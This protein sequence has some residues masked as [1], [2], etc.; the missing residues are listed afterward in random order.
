[1]KFFFQTHFYG[2]NPHDVG[3]IFSIR[4]LW[5]FIDGVQLYM[6]KTNDKYQV[7]LTY[8]VYITYKLLQPTFKVLVVSTHLAVLVGKNDHSICIVSLHPVQ[9][10]AFH[11]RTLHIKYWRIKWVEKC[12][13]KKGIETW[14][15]L[16][17]GYFFLRNPSN[18][19]AGSSGWRNTASTSTSF[20]ILVIEKF[21]F[22][23]S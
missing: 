8:K 5:I 11:E 15:Y 12:R 10:V 9:I 1:M 18:S 13:K 22:F 19:R 6:V 17:L 20:I 14:K 16:T 7:C 23:W 2:N 21:N 4:V 3:S